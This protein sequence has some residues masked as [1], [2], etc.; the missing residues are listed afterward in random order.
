VCAKQNLLIGWPNNVLMLMHRIAQPELTMVLLL[1]SLSN[2]IPYV[3]R[4]TIKAG[5]STLAS[6]LGAVIISAN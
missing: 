4:L 3:I 5:T 2:N 1:M 6:K